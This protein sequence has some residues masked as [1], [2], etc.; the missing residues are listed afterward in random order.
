MK[1]TILNGN[2]YAEDTLFD[3]Y[4]ENISRSLE[5]G[6]HDVNNLRL[7]EMDIKNCL[8]CFGC[9]LR[10]PG[11]CVVNDDS[12][13]VR[14]EF[15]NSDFALFTSPVIMGFTSALLKKVVDKLLPLVLPYKEIVYGECH[16]MSRYD[17]YPLLGL[18]LQKDKDV[19]E[20]DIQII[21]DIY[22]RIAVQCQSKLCFTLFA[23]NEII[24]VIDEI[25]NLHR[26]A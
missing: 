26:F 2:P 14:R 25:N 8:G 22:R 9:W 23:E 1:I 18:I 24:E 21:S 10:T 4:L 15:I 7:R 13:F 20:E 16:N 5:S 6:S 17:R 11:R 19:D 3:D 12:D